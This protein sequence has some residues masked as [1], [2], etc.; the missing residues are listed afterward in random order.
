MMRSIGWVFE[1]AMSTVVAGKL[2]RIAAS[3]A[4]I[5]DVHYGKSAS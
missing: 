1:T 2:E 3:C 4:L 5:M